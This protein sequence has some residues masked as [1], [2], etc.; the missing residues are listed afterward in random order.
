MGLL[1]TVKDPQDLAKLSGKELEE[2]AGEIRKFLITNVAATGG[3]LG[4]NLGV[5][6]LTLAVHRM[7]DSP[8]DSIVFDTGHQSYVHKLLT[9]RQDFSTLRQQGGLSGYPERAESEHDIV[10]SSHASSSLSWAD[11]ISRARQLTGEGDR[12]V[13]AVVGDGALTGGMTWEAINNIAADKRRRVVIVVNDNGRSYAPTVGGFADY[14]ASLR[15]TIDS[16]RTAPAY[17]RMLDWWKKKLQNG[18]PAGQFTYKSLHA[19]KKGIKDWWAPQGMFEDLGMKYIGPVDGHNL[20]AMEHALNTAKAYG[21]PVI[22]HAMTEKGHGYAPALANEAD[23]FHA[24]GIIDPETGESTE[25]PGA[26]SWTSVFAEEIADIADEREDIVGITGAMLIPVGLHKF[27]ERH[28]ERVIDVGIAEQHALTSAAGMAFGGLHPVVA[29]YATFLNRA[30]D[31]LLMDVALH[32]AGVTIVLDRAGVTGP[33]G[34][35]HHGMWDMA[36]VQIVPGLHLAAPRDATRLREELREAVAINDAPTVVRFSK[37]SVGSEVE[38]I[39]RLHDGVDILARRPA[40]STENDVLIVSVGAM[41]ELALDV[42][43]RLGAQGISS[44]VVDPRWVLPVR[45]SIIA[46]AARHRLV[47]CIEDG[48]RAG[49]VGSRIRQEMRAAGVDTALNEVGL[50]VEFLVHGSRS[51]VL[52]RVGLTAQKITHDVVAQVLGTKVPFARPLPG[53]EHPTTGSLPTL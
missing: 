37:G 30:F 1:E 43:D 47:I 17:E 2:L 4:P 35:S 41:S 24:V 39:E 8:R 51:Q 14:L 38:A 46:L 44:T 48:V 21:G 33:D 42:A 15:P 12:F 9:G 32:K 16:L 29:V 18:G 7:F 28:P 36:M 11:G 6:E 27:A 20:Q 5:V 50:P 23:Q 10:E 45:K 25:I 19:M 3:H 34:P 40:G 13:V 31:Q 49:G 52:E 53:Q 26:R 22:V